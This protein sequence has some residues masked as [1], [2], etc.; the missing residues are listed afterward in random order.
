M[1]N[2]YPTNENLEIES[3]IRMKSNLLNTRITKEL[4]KLETLMKFRAFNNIFWGN[5]VNGFQ[6]V[7]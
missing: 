5:T 2:V 3:E 6:K 4:E 1:H 7:D